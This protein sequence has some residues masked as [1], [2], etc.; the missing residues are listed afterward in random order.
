MAEGE[1]NARI[2]YWGIAG[3]GTTANLRT[4]HSKLRPDHRGPLEE[5]P[6]RIDPSVCYERLLI[7]LGKIAG[8]RTRIQITTVPGS[9]EH[10]ATRKQLIDR[11]DGV[12]LVL[13][14]RPECIDANLA[15]FDELRRALA[16]Y[17][18]RLEDLPLVV[19][20]NKRDLSDPFVL[21]EL[22]RKLELPHAAVFEAV[23]TKGAGVLQTLTTISKRV[24]RALRDPG[25]AS[26]PAVVPEP[27]APAP[28]E[29]PQAAAAPMERAQPVSDLPEIEPPQEAPPR[30]PVA[31]PALAPHEP[32]LEVDPPELAAPAP[33][34]DSDQVAARAQSMLDTGWDEIAEAEQVAD[35]ADAWC[36]T[37]VGDAEL[38]G[39]RSLSLPVRAVDGLGK[40]VRFRLNVSLESF[41]DDPDPGLSND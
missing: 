15:C 11:I 25:R 24:V 22:H 20:Y 27:A 3:A 10:V 4:I 19:Q 14:G 31:A 8:Q 35:D 37:G 13:D 38:T 36:L 12:V 16:A 23:A 39:P 7:E 40:E 28:L 32:V 1:V 21:E 5:V 33:L 29:A 41:D 6:T 9:P 34:P 2:V 18:R 17:G 30:T 26:A